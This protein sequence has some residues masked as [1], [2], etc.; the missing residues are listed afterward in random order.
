MH[1]NFRGYRAT[2]VVRRRV[3]KGYRCS[4]GYRKV[5][6]RQATIGRVGYTGGD[7]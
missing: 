4:Q 3:Y 7:G 6:Y 1:T 2:I 5:S